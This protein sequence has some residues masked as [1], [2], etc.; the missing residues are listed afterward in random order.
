MRAAI[1]KIICSCVI[2]KATAACS[3]L[4]FFLL[5]PHISDCSFY[6]PHCSFFGD[7]PLFLRLKLSRGTIIT[8]NIGQALVNLKQWLRKSSSLHRQLHGGRGLNSQSLACESHT[9]NASTAF[10]LLCS[11][12][13]FCHLISIM[14]AN[15]LLHSIIQIDN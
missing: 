15:L 4:P 12:C 5:F 10:S 6:E 13:F 2:A 8:A 11:F 14:I 9:L 7:W 3:Q 1:N